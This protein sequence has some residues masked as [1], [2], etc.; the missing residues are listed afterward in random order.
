MDNSEMRKS[1]FQIIS[2]SRV[3]QTVCQKRLDFEFPSNLSR[4]ASVVN[5][6]RLSRE[7]VRI[8]NRT[9]RKSLKLGNARLTESNV[10]LIALNARFNVVDRF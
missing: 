6:G 4:K 9:F 1:N 8:A 2:T 10:A 5:T 3:E 7:M